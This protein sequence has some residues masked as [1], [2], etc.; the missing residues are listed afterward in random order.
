MFSLCQT[1]PVSG[2][3][4]NPV[5]PTTGSVTATI[6]AGA[7]PTFAVFL[8]GQGDIPLDAALN[9]AFVRFEDDG[10]TPPIGMARLMVPAQ[11]AEAMGLAA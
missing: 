7:T 3:C 2:A 8:T 9:R 6:N 5:A 1:D 10:G 11:S 4:I